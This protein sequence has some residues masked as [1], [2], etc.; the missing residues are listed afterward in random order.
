MYIRMIR[1]SVQPSNWIFTKG[2]GFL[3]L[4]R[5]MGKNLGKNISKNVCG[6]HSQKRLDHAKQSPTDPLKIASKR[7]IHKKQKQLVI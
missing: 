3:S 1:Y 2:Y 6:K 7:A 5:N 4:A